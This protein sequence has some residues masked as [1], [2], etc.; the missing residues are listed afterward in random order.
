M[1]DTKITVGID[2]DLES[3]AIRAFINVFS[4]RETGFHRW[5]TLFSR[6]GKTIFRN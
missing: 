2:Q 3:M 4:G 5:A 1:R 6:G